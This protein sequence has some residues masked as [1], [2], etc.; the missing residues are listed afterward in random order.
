VVAGEVFSNI[1]SVSAGYLSE[2]LRQTYHWASLK[3]FSVCSNA[4]GLAA[5]LLD[6]AYH[7]SLGSGV[8]RIHCT[9][10]ASE[11][12]DPATAPDIFRPSSADQE[13]DVYHASHKVNVQNVPIHGGHLPEQ[14]AGDPPEVSEKDQK[15]LQLAIVGVPNAGKSTLTNALVGQKV[16]RAMGSVLVRLLS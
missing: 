16:S 4:R 6:K 8:R 7:R 14:E 2:G 5:L 13:A 1:N 15:L 10:N 12:E 3:T 11:P 9:I